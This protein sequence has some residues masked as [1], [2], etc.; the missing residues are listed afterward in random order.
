MRYLQLA[1]LTLLCTMVMS[2]CLMV[3]RAPTR[4]PRNSPLSKQNPVALPPAVERQPLE[5]R[6]RQGSSA[7][8]PSSSSP[9]PTV[10]RD[11]PAA[12]EQLRL[13][14]LGARNMLL[15]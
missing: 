14:E 12:L 15:Y 3:D 11:L 10:P 6:E 2:M 9:E 8:P 7:Q 4:Q 1:A 5:L 13:L